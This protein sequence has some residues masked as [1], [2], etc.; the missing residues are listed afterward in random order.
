M[1]SIGEAIAVVNLLSAIAIVIILFRFV[2][3]LKGSKLYYATGFL[4]LQ[5]MMF[6]VHALT[7]VLNLDEIYYALTALVASVALFFAIYFANQSVRELGG[8]TI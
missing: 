5:S 7:E 2:V 6:V 1:I 4:V 8:E 3:H